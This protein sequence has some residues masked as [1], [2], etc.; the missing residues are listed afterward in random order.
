MHTFSIGHLNLPKV[1]RPGTLAP[2]V[3]SRIMTK[4][5]GINFL[6]FRQ[7]STKLRDILWRIPLTTIAR[8]L[9][10]ILQLVDHALAHSKQLQVNADGGVQLAS[11]GTKVLRALNGIGQSDDWKLQQQQ[12]VASA[13]RQAIEKSLT[14][15]GADA[16]A[17]KYD[18]LFSKVREINLTAQP[19]ELPVQRYVEALGSFD[20]KDTLLLAGQHLPAGATAQVEAVAGP[21]DYRPLQD[22]RASLAA[23][24]MVEHE[25]KQLDPE[26]AAT[27]GNW[28][29][30]YRQ[31]AQSLLVA[32]DPAQRAAQGA[33]LLARLTVLANSVDEAV[34]QSSPSPQAAA[35]LDRLGERISGE[36]HL[37]GAVIANKADLS[38]T[39]DVSW[40]Q[41]VELRRLGID[42]QEG[43]LH[44]SRLQNHTVKHLAGGGMNQVYTVKDEQGREFVY[45]P[46]K[47]HVDQLEAAVLGLAQKMGADVLHPEML[48]DRLYD[49][50][51]SN[52]DTDK[53]RVSD[54]RYE[55]RNVAASRL[56]ALLDTHVMVGSRLALVPKDQLPLKNTAANDDQLLAANEANQRA[57]DETFSNFGLLMDKAPGKDA[58]HVTQSAAY[59]AAHHDPA[60]LRDL[61]NLQLLDCI[62]CSLDRH[63]GNFM[64][65]ISPDGQYQGLKGI[66][67]DFSLTDAAF[68]VRLF[69]EMTESDR[70]ILNGGGINQVKEK[71]L[72]AFLFS[73]SSVRQ[74][75]VLANQMT[76][77]GNDLTPEMK[78]RIQEICDQY[79][80]DYRA[81]KMHY[82]AP[83]VEQLPMVLRLRED[84]RATGLPDAHPLAQFFERCKQTQEALAAVAIK[85]VDLVARLKVHG[86]T[87]MDMSIHNVGLPDVAD[88]R[89][90]QLLLAP[91]FEA[92]M[93]A[94]F[95]GLLTPNEVNAAVQRLQTV[96]TH[97]RKL[98]S[99]GRLLD[100]TQWR[101]DH[102]DKQ[103]N[104]V[105]TLLSDAHH[106]HFA[107]L[108][109]RFQ[110]WQAKEAAKAAKASPAAGAVA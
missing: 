29:D 27:L 89:T 82:I 70:V 58:A 32:V 61:S 72:D 18:R 35:A 85:K 78:T 9:P 14:H 5:A 106:N 1:N 53:S 11:F 20:R 104:T 19:G 65:D 48:N 41:A 6:F 57:A 84:I 38:K 76:Q 30:S 37:I 100:D 75:T 62:L 16:S 56:D 90:A 107:R 36:I 43:V 2:Q 105:E 80:A 28:L 15:S 52:K 74:A 93:K 22:V 12:K 94:S 45:K 64:I 50:S 60:F 108:D 13:V 92:R 67:N 59:G 101:M 49:K 109:W 102:K 34:N 26:L 24:R 3:S 54:M 69:E 40:R 51:G 42:M 17:N 97:L 88:L 73:T 10:D 39:P 95:R 86:Q 8:A 63:P 83:G 33:Q 47:A 44:D 81:Q 98:E 23:E 25:L 87:V 110:E 21:Q 31:E 68:D 91:D 46:G 7:M 77:H 66:D 4:T 79:Q 55:A 99:E 103:G 96:Q 71:D